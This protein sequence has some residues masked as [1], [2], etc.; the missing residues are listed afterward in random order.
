M[1]VKYYING[2]EYLYLDNEQKRIITDR[3]AK[4]LGLTP[5]D[6]KDQGTKHDIIA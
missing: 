2:T 5:V 1:T 3:I 6:S 4:A